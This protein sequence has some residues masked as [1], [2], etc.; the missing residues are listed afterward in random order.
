MEVS[1]LAAQAMKRTR[2]GISGLAAS[3]EHFSE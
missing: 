3:H 1:A 2:D